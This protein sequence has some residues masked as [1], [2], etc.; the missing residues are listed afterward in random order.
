[1]KTNKYIITYLEKRLQQLTGTLVILIL[2]CLI[3]FFLVIF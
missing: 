2:L 3:F 1:M